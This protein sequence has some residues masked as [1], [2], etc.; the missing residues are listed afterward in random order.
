[1][2]GASRDCR[3]AVPAHQP[4][5]NRHHT[6]RQGGVQYSGNCPLP[7]Q[8]STNHPHQLDISRRHSAQQIKWH[9]HPHPNR[10]TTKCTPQNRQALLQGN[11][12][13]ECGSDRNDRIGDFPFANVSKYRNTQETEQYEKRKRQHIH[14][15]WAKSLRRSQPLLAEPMSSTA[16]GTP[17]KLRVRRVASCAMAMAS[18]KPKS[19]WRC[20]RQAG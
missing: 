20:I 18:C 14:L 4:Q 19:G 1:M 17:R 5:H 3:R 11:T 8:K 2:A 13:S 6:A 16:R 9:Q 7:S 12:C 10:P 15:S